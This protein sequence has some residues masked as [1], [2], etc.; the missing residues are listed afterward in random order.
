[1]LSGNVICPAVLVGAPAVLL[2]PGWMITYWEFE[3]LAS[4]GLFHNDP[5]DA[6]SA[7][8]EMDADCALATPVSTS[9]H[10]SRPEAHS[11]PRI[12]PISLMGYSSLN[13]RVPTADMP[14]E[15]VAS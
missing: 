8:S 11:C 15:S 1:M 7:S 13:C 9:A 4:V 5:T 12:D 10:S 14:G 3:A 2:L 6:H